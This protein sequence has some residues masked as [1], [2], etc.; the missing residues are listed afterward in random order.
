MQVE[1]DRS[2]PELVE[3]FIEEAKEEIENIR[4]NLPAWTADRT[5]SEALIATRRSFHTLKGS[6]RMVGAQLIGEFAWSIENLLNRLINQTLEPTPSM[7][8]FITE[9]SGALPQL[10]EQLEIGLPPKVDVQLLMK[11]AEAFAE[12]DPD[13]ASLTGQ[14]LRVAALAPRPQPGAARARHGSRAG[15]HLRQR[16]ARAPRGHSAVPG[17]GHAR[18]PGR[19][20][21]RS[22]SI[23]RATRCSAARGWPGSSRR[24]SSAAPLAE[25]LRRYFDSGT[26]VT[27]AGVDAL[28]TAAD[29]IEA[30][31]DALAAGRSY[32]LDPGVLTALEPLAF[33]ERAPGAAPASAA[34]AQ[35]PRSRAASRARAR[36]A[37]ERLR[38]RDRR[39]LR[40]GSGR[41]PRQL[42]GRIARGPAAAGSV[43]RRDAAAFP[44]HAER[45]RAHG[46]RAADGRLEPRAR[47]A[48]ARASRKA[49]AGRRRRRSISCS[50]GST[51]CSRCATPSM[52]VARWR[53]RRAHRAA[54]RLRGAGR[55]ASRCRPR[56][57][58]GGAGARR[59]AVAVGSRGTAGRGRAYVAAP[60]V[61][62]RAGAP[63][64]RMSRRST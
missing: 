4:R 32:E 57:R 55:R 48:A 25:H 30:M 37:A 23:A 15:R 3:V 58:R 22:R 61:A 63:R 34:P 41:D 13:A 14:S 10:L 45:R 47:D 6:G 39:D 27:D 44:A 18:R 59:A 9:A 53:R 46:R 50:A 2:D 51:S 43:R 40:R 33:R 20:R 64:P 31:A 19:T 49:A 8:A 26:G 35:A 36:V 16:D 42:P 54:R 11:Q 1:E 21:S 24:C 12:G 5:N 7:I 60:P 56:R 29:E 62:R 28:R 52:R 38:S 17:R